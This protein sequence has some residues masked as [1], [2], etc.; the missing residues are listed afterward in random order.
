VTQALARALDL[1]DSGSSASDDEA[2]ILAPPLKRPGNLL[3]QRMFQNPL[4]PLL[5]KVLLK[6]SSL[7]TCFESYDVELYSLLIKLK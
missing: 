3:S 2:A 5:R 1:F 7:G 4:G 6:C